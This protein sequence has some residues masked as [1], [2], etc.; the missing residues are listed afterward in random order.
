MQ[1][2]SEVLFLAEILAVRRHESIAVPAASR[3]P[4]LREE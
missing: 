2:E 3:K 4:R 1:W